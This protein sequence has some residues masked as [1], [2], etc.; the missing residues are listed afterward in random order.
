LHNLDSEQPASPYQKIGQ[1]EKVHIQTKQTGEDNP[2][3]IQ[4]LPENI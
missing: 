4:M 2:M 1:H 3:S